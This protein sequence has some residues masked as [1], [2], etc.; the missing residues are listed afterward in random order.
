MPT[1]GSPNGGGPNPLPD[2]ETD[3]SE[4]NSETTGSNT[5]IPEHEYGNYYV[6]RHGRLFHTSPRSRYFLPADEEESTRLIEQHEI[7]QRLLGGDYYQPLANKLD[8]AG[9]RQVTVL[10]LGCGPGIWV[11]EFSMEYPSAYF[12]GI[13]LVLMARQQLENGGLSGDGGFPLQQL[14]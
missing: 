7:F 8:A 2:A 9:S 6:Q 14:A 5:T 12:I 11:E 4:T 10:D 1:P 3:A 13:D